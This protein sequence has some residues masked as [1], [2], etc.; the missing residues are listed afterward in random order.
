MALR[1]AMAVRTLRLLSTGLIGCL[2]AG[3]ADAFGNNDLVIRTGSYPEAVTLNKPVTI[4]PDGGPV[5]IGQ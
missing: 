4:F 3:H 5:T 1:R 2:V